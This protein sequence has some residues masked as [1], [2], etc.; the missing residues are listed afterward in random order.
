M[1][2]TCP[3]VHVIVQVRDFNS[4][5]ELW[6]RFCFYLGGKGITNL[7]MDSHY[8]APSR[9][10]AIELERETYLHSSEANTHIKQLDDDSDQEC[11]GGTTEDV[12]KGQD[13]EEGSDGDATVA[14]EDGEKD[15]EH[16]DLDGH[17]MIACQNTS[18]GLCALLE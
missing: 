1:A 3:Q 10:A 9:R 14:E 6:T 2:L 16:Q 15:D 11:K 18:D 4:T 13:G 5:T 17:V 8:I 12:G 7:S